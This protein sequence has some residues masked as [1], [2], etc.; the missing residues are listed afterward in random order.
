MNQLLLVDEI[1]RATP[2]TQ[3]SL[4]ETMAEHQVTVD[5]AIYKLPKPFM[6]IATQNPAE[7]IGT[8]PLEGYSAKPESESTNKICDNTRTYRSCWLW[9]MAQRQSPSKN[10]FI[11]GR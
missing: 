6:V 5:G 2:K 10:I 8:Y 1:N 7:Y 4:L 9:K 3:S 11:C